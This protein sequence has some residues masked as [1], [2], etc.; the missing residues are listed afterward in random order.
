[1]SPP[2]VPN[3]NVARTTSILRRTI[4]LCGIVVVATILLFAIAIIPSQ[5]ESLL[6]SLRSKA[7]LVSTSIADIAAGAIVMEDYSAVVDHCMKI[8]HN[9]ES[10]PYIIITRKDGFSLIHKANGWTTDQLGGDYLHTG[11][12]EPH[13]EIVKTAITKDKVYQYCSPLVYSGIEWGWIHVG[14][15]L[16]KYNQDAHRIYLRT[17][18]M[19]VACILIGMVLTFFYSKKL[20]KPIHLL[21]EATKR[22][23][24]GDL[25]ARAEV[26]S[27][28]EVEILSDSFNSMTGNLQK[29]HEELKAARDYTQ[30]IIQSMNDLLIVCSPDGKIL[31]IN[32]AA[33]E[34]L[35][36]SMEDITGKRITVIL[37]DETV[38]ERDANGI[39]AMQ[40]RR[41]VEKFL[42]ASD[43]RLIPVLLSCAVL[44]SEEGTAQGIVYVAA[45]ISERK[46][47]EEIR[48]KREEQR[49]KQ[50]EALMHL[51]GQ[52]LIHAG[53]LHLA[54]RRITKHSAEVLSVSKASLWLY[55]EK[56]SAMECIDCY[57]EPSSMHIKLQSLRASDYP[58][59]F[60]ALELDRA[61][62]AS[63]ALADARTRELLKDYLIPHGI[64]SMLDAPIRLAGQ[65]VGVLCHA[66]TGGIRQWTLDEQNF[67]GSMADL[68]SLAL[69]GCSRRKAQEELKEAKEQAEAANRAKSSFLANMSHEIRT[70]LNAIIGYS[71]MLH[72]DAED[73]GCIGIVPDLQKITSA[74]KHLLGVISDVLDLSKIE[75]G[76]MELISEVFDISEMLM[77]LSTT[78]EPIIEKNKNKFQLNISADLGEMKADKTRVRQIVFNLLSNA[79]KFTQNGIV[80]LE[81]V[82]EQLAEM[83]HMRFSVRDTG[84]GISTEQ[85]KKL[86][87]D[88]TQADASMTRKYGGT[89][90]GLS[91][92][93]RICE[94]MGG[95]ISLESEFG[96]GSL[97]TVMIPVDPQKCASRIA[98]PPPKIN[99]LSEYLK[100]FQMERL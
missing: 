67:V 85:Q 59:Y 90:L 41:N 55:N 16:D 54:S 80:T 98:Q 100:E 3:K 25:S 32:R 53:D 95:K 37:L 69:E 86:F 76:K 5:R 46:K 97:F 70:P 68:A 7:Q 14:L 6:D 2:S 43:G 18:L 84:I 1:M 57:D 22:V 74:G 44:M 21:T 89:G 99:S 51:A 93:K 47:G 31:T 75:A 28:D 24:A 42:R 64:T 58:G 52:K 17:V 8:V 96:N 30:N 81:A 65:V 83:D 66:Y 15:S 26:V 36:Y 49:K 40:E 19:G 92:T 56:R 27:G 73:L 60:T 50:K 35:Q 78:M 29:V 38:V 82:R 45:D 71:E 9:G 72:E 13:G 39:I 23:A 4:T 87:H 10:V 94:M 62:A 33:C 63:D 11:S 61:I 91:I 20:V 88:F 77:E 48:Q 12:L 34:L 79:A